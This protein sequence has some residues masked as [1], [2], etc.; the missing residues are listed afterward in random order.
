MIQKKTITMVLVLA[1][2][3]IGAIGIGTG[4]ATQ[5]A[6]AVP[7]SCDSFGRNFGGGSG[8]GV[9][10]LAWGTNCGQNPTQ[11]GQNPP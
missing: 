10:G 2:A 3:A 5:S 9:P 1:I 6:Q 11:T 4:T 7:S 8:S